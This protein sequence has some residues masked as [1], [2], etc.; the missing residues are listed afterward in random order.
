M[1]FD[2]DPLAG[3][4]RRLDGV[5]AGLDRQRDEHLI[6]GVAGQQRLQIVERAQHALADGEG[7]LVVAAG[8]V[9]EAEHPVVRQRLGLDAFEQPQGPRTAA[10]D[11]QPHRAHRAFGGVARRQR[12]HR[13]AGGL[14]D[15]GTGPEHHGHLGAESAL[16]ADEGKEEQGQDADAAGQDDPPG[17]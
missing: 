7:H 2:A 6:D 16:V 5:V 12:H 8:R 3:G 11:D 13:A 10:D 9:D 4:D 1:N 14:D 15:D 17:L